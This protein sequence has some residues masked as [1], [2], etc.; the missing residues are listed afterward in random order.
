VS[1]LLVPAGEKAARGIAAE[2]WHGTD[3]IWARRRQRMK[4]G[5]LDQERMLRDPLFA[6]RDYR[7]L[8]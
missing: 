7:R 1:I 8:I 6:D 4:F 3:V 5:K 2:S